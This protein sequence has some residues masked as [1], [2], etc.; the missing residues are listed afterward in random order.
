MVTT[1]CVGGTGGG[2]PRVDFV[3]AKWRGW[4]SR[5]HRFHRRD[6]RIRRRRDGPC[7][8]ELATW[9][10]DRQLDRSCRKIQQLK[11]LTPAFNV[12]AHAHSSVV[13]LPPQQSQP[14]K[15][16]RSSLQSGFHTPRAFQQHVGG[17][18]HTRPL[19]PAAHSF[20]KVA[21]VLNLGAYR[22]FSTSNCRKGPELLLKAAY[23]LKSA[24][25]LQWIN[26]LFRISVSFIPLSLK[27]ASWARKA[28]MAQLA[29]GAVIATPYWQTFFRYLCRGALALPFVLLAAVLLAA[30]ERT[31]ITGRLRLL[32]LNQEE[33]RDI[34]EKVLEIGAIDQLPIVSEKT[35]P[36][37]KGIHRDW[38]AIM[39]TVLGEEEAPAGT[40]LGGKVLDQD[41]WRT[42]LV[43]DVLM[44]LEH[45]IPLLNAKA[46]QPKL[47]F[48]PPALLHPLNNSTRCSHQSTHNAVIVIDRPESNAFS[49]GFYGSIDEPQPG[50]VIVF[51]G[52]I[53]E[54]LAGHQHNGTSPHSKEPATE[55][56][57]MPTYPTS[58]TEPSW[59][60]SFFGK[61]VSPAQMQQQ[62]NERIHQHLTTEQEEALSVLLAHE[63]AHLVLSHTIESYANTALLWPQ[64]EK[65]GWDMLRVFIYPV[66]V[67]LGPFVQDAI[68]ATVKVG[69]EE[70]AE[71]RGLLPALTSSCESKKLEFEAD[72]VALRLLANAGLDPRSAVKFWEERLSRHSSP[73]HVAQAEM[74][75]DHL[76]DSR[77]EVRHMHPS[78]SSND[79]DTH[80]FI[81]THP[82]DEERISA[83][84]KE[85]ARWRSVAA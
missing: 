14:P 34:V 65:L 55:S 59:L 18:W 27:R 40:L 31:P 6:G 53:D 46:S 41:D 45:G 44:K 51:T 29:T 35:H 54:I 74:P 22:L 33:E 8:L 3:H 2:A 64:L 84:K 70:S 72:A 42:K 23:L 81:K 16:S 62:R 77:T 60:R 13:S 38:L 75:Y 67:F 19:A 25:A 85:L 4:R 7:P 28:R 10:L 61:L 49:F 36:L 71:G 17:A 1:P 68:S 48:E 66:T 52:A 21:P 24:N 12:H 47:V 37:A 11:K 76:A 69:I 5:Y 32:L 57:A 78:V 83:I 82:A 50:V 26:L 43:E 30:L 58:Y 39:R 63:L 80:S 56:Q 73:H 79:A 9:F 15:S 20:A